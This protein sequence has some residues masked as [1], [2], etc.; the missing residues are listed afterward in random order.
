MRGANGRRVSRGRFRVVGCGAF[1][2][3][4]NP[5]GWQIKRAE[6]NSIDA[7]NELIGAELFEEPLRQDHMPTATSSRCSR[8]LRDMKRMERPRFQ[9]NKPYRW[10]R[11]AGHF[12][13]QSAL[14]VG[15]SA[16]AYPIE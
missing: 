7:A 8:L 10:S 6:F 15:P 4:F 11:Y 1:R 2:L 3:D 5:H 14:S 13:M 9:L 16:A 12:T